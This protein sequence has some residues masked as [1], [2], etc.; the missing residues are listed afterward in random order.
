MFELTVPPARTPAPASGPIA[1]STPAPELF[2]GADSCLWLRSGDA[3]HAV[4][5]VRC[6]PWS[7]ADRFISLRSEDGTEHCL[8]EDLD[9]LSPDSRQALARAL[10]PVGFVLE[11]EAIE[12]IDED[13]EVRVW[14]TR[15]RHGRRTFQTALDAWP[16]PAPAG[17]YFV[18]DIGGDLFRLPPL[19]QLD[20]ASR[21]K[22]FA[23]VG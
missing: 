14:R 6:F 7:R 3:T 18:Q 17:G 4:R 20:E 11:L 2:I 9:A 13:Y 12:S 10:A 1:A 16:W 8:V 22:L 5:P 19:E 21:R 15:T 23:Y